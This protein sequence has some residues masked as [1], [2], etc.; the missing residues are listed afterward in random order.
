MTTIDEIEPKLRAAVRSAQKDGMRCFKAAVSEVPIKTESTLADEEGKDAGK[1]RVLSMVNA[2]KEEPGQ[3]LDREFMRCVTK[4]VEP[5][6]CSLFLF[7][8]DENENIDGSR[9]LLVCWLPADAS[10]LQRAVHMR[11]RGLM[12]RFVPQPYFLSELLAKD[13]RQLTWSAAREACGVNFGGGLGKVSKE[14][15]IVVPQ[16]QAEACMQAYPPVRV[17]LKLTLKCEGL[18]QRLV[19]R[20]ESCL[21]LTLL[22]EEHHAGVHGLGRA[23]TLDALSVNSK[24][25]WSLADSAR[26]T[27]PP[28]DCYFAML[29]NSTAGELTL[30]V[31]LWCP[32]S[33]QKDVF[34]VTEDIRHASLK[35]TVAERLLQAFPAAKGQPRLVMIDARDPQ[36]IVDSAA[37]QASGSRGRSAHAPPS[38]MDIGNALSGD[39]F[40]LRGTPPAGVTPTASIPC[41]LQLPERPMPPWRGGSKSHTIGAPAPSR[42]A[43]PRKSMT[44][45]LLAFDLAAKLEAK[46][47]HNLGY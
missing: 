25:P 3:A 8:S 36:D 24:S 7:R 6:K 21:R 39:T 41:T 16:G 1:K 23:S 46:A 2:L 43:Q 26:T 27:L 37:G 18:L 20:E 28:H 19:R 42:H 40:G 34:R 17:P 30:L 10:E 38:Q 14:M 5:K 13:H 31:I 33:Q 29:L 32:E 45:N 22:K 47:V 4:Q 12:A 15:L 44:T 11:S 9:W 35:S